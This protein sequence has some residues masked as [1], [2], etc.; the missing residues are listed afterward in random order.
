MYDSMVI[1]NVMSNTSMASAGA[2]PGSRRG[3]GSVVPE[4]LSP[5]RDVPA[6]EQRG[7]YLEE[8]VAGSVFYHSP[9][10]TVTEAD[11]TMFTTMT[12]NTQSLHLDAHW[13]ATQ[14]FGKP[15]VNS[16]FTLSALVGL[17]VGQLT[18][19]T[20]SAN[21]G[22]EAVSFP[23]PVFVGDTLYAETVIESVRDSASRP[24]QG[25]VTFLHWM[26]NQEGAIVALCTRST[27][28]WRST[29]APADGR[30]REVAAD[31]AFSR[32]E[33]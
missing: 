1:E 23:A 3:R 14:P 10:R 13:S 16:L 7:L 18:Q 33:R 27:L 30:P 22:F 12:M 2:C 6:F 5:A 29:H 21:L 4:D 17:S 9:G 20:I 11:N 24:G 25:I 26:R 28:M 8:F 15:L 31:P 19:G 32:G